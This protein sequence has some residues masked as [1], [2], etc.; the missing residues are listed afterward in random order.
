MK[1]VDVSVKRPIGVIMIVIA[2][3]L[4][5]TISLKNLA[6]DLYPE[7]NLPITIVV[8]DYEGAA[9]QEVEKMVS[10]PL[11]GVL[12]TIEGIKKVR[13][14]SAPGQSLIILE[15]DWGSNMDTKINSIRDK[16]DLVTN[17]LPDEVSKP[18]VLKMDPTAIPIVR[19]SV[20]GDMEASRLSNIAEDIIKPRLERT[21]GVANVDLIGNKEKEIKVEV[22]PIYLNG[23][24][25]SINQIIQVLAGENIATTAG[26][27]KRGDQELLLRINGE[28]SS[29]EEIKNL[30]IPLPTGG[31]VKLDEI[32]NITEDYKKSDTITKVSGKPSLS[33]D[34]SKKSDGNTIKVAN[35]LYKSLEKI[36][37]I[38]PEGVKIDI[39]YDLSIF[40]RQSVDNVVR[41]LIIGGSLATIILF[42]FLRS[43]RSTLVIAI[44]MPIA[45]IT[46]FN[47]IYFTGESL[48]I[49]TLGGLAL[50]IGMMVD[51]SIVILEN[52]FRY[53]ELGYDRI[54]A[55]KEG[56]KEVGSA[57][58][59][60]AL[61][62]VAVFL[63]IVFVEGLAAELF[64]PLALTVSFALIASLIA[65]LT[66][67]PMLS[68]Y[69]LQNKQKEQSKIMSSVYSVYRRSLE[70]SLNHRKTVVF[71]TLALILATF[72]LVPMV[73]TE[74][75]PQ[76]DQGEINIDITL[77]EGTLLEET[78]KTIDY[79]V[80]RLWEIKE[81]DTIF[82]S[83]GSG[84]VFSMGVSNTNVG[85]IYVRLVP[86][87]ERKRSTDQVMEEIRRLTKKIPGAEINVSQ[88][89]SG[90][91]GSSAPISITITG[92]DLKVLN[93]LAEQIKA[94]V[95]QVKGTRN[96][97]NTAEEG[98]PEMQIIVDQE[99][100]AMY[101]LNFSQIMSTVKTGFNGQ[102]ATRFRSQGQE[103]DVRVTLPEEYKQDMKQ[104]EDILIQTPYGSAIPLKEVAEL[105][106]VKGPAQIEREDQR[107]KVNV[108]SDIVN[109]DLGSITKDIEDRL[110]KIQ[111]PEGYIVEIGGQV[112]DMAESFGSL[113]YALILAI[114]L[115]Y[116]V[117]AVQFEA[118]SYPFI[119]MFSM[120]ATFIGIVV[121]LVVTGRTLSVAAFVGVI[122]LAGI[123]V[124][125]AIVLVDYINNLRKKGNKRSEAILIAGPNRLRPILMT[126]LTTILGLIPLTLGIGE[127]A[128]T[129][130]P[131]A[132]VVVFGLGFSTLVTL[133]LVPVV[134]TYID[135][136]EKWFK[137]KLSFKR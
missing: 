62:T 80:E 91:F 8:T 1:I 133:L 83:A 46:T 90:G 92:E 19:L 36:E 60:S 29:I 137:R 136:F 65:S 113:V 27:I 104:V 117:M 33:F 109:R 48:N 41:N 32:A 53:Q 69:L 22:A 35:E 61:T 18:L 123:V 30:L 128:E 121:G 9:P 127:G 57:V 70:W 118:V 7:I 66:I 99:K 112:E 50:G 72:A 21:S 64:R 79:I 37:K 26:N 114:F 82:T 77:P 108:T 135:D 111:I 31:T 94:E 134:Y 115:V 49:L 10:E 4:M 81:V 52:I 101:G 28:F 105:V 44:T 129:Q 40:I 34:I 107:R 39:V 20:S 106:Q 54:E 17:I 51:S 13:S 93:N 100:A 5:G 95:E 24:G 102:V 98:R 55:A 16:L 43:V 59:A 71:G 11:E 12:G 84:G 119:I 130:A 126:T 15:F 124:N 45:V 110:K 73:G 74:F 56:A 86:L 47:L 132:T 120:P 103:I 63:P 2:I 87:S 131:F 88:I 67:V 85:N 89:Q 125:N 6:I 14:I 68:A 25:L 122:M 78:D 23:Y 116:M 38:L 76:M 96:V 97:I 3:I 75:L 58:I 42:Y